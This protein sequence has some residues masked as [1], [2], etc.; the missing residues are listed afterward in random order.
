MS[1]ATD[2]LAE[3][4]A[5]ET[6]VLKG[7]RVRLENGGVSRDVTMADLAEIRKG[8]AYWQLEVAKEK[9]A[10]SGDRSG[11]L[12]YRVPNFVSWRD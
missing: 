12:R 8:I 7:Q 1:I 11:S 10:E 5:A 2:K 3:Y 6:K 9:A 4:L